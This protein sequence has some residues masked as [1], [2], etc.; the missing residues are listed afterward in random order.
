MGQRTWEHIKD[1]FNEVLEAGPDRREGILESEPGEVRRE[2]EAL[3]AAHERAKDAGDEDHP[4][5]EGPGSRIGRYKVLQEIGEGGFGVVYMAEQEEPVRRKVALKVIKLGMDTKQVIARFEAERQAL[6][7]LDHPNIAKVLDA[8][9]TETGRPYFVMELVKGIP[10]TEYCDKAS[11][12]TP[13]RLAL[14]TDV[15]R[16]I[17]HAHRKGIIHRD[18]KPSNVLVTLH[19]GKPVPKVI[20]FGIAKATDR[21]LTEKTLFTEFRQVVGTPDYMAPEQAELSSLDIDTRADVYSLGVLLYELLTGSKPFE[22]KT[23]LRQGW[24][25]ILRYIRE[26]DPPKPSTKLSTMGEEIGVVARNRRTPPKLL[27][28]LVRG[29]LDWIVLKALEKDRSRRY[30]SADAMAQDVQRFLDDQPVQATPPSTFYAIRKYVK[31]HK[32][33]VAAAAAVLL[34]LVVGLVLSSLGFLEASRQKGEAV[35]E[36]DAA[37]KAR[38]SEAEARRAADRAVEQA[39]LE[40]DEKEAARADLAEALVK[41]EG[42]RLLAQSQAVLPRDPA[43]A[44][45]LAIEGAERAPGFQANQALLAALEKAPLHE[46]TLDTDSVWRAAFGPRGERVATG[47]G[48]GTIRVFSADSG[49]EIRSFRLGDGPIA[50]LAWQ[51]GRDRIVA[52]G[53]DGEIGAWDPVGGRRLV[54]IRGDERKKRLQRGSSAWIND[55]AARVV[56]Y[57]IG[58][59]FQVFDLERGTL[60]RTLPAVEMHQ[61][62]VSP[63]G[64]WL[65]ARTERRSGPA[66]AYEVTVRSLETGEVR[67]AWPVENTNPDARFS[68][69][70][71]RVLLEAAEGVIHLLDVESGALLQEIRLEGHSTAAGRLNSGFSSDG[72]RVYVAAGPASG[73]WDAETGRRLLRIPESRGV[74]SA[75]MSPG[76]E[77]LLIIQRLEVATAKLYCVSSGVELWQMPIASM[78]THPL[79]SPDGGRILVTSHNGGA[80]I[81]DLTVD[82]MR[83]RGSGGTFFCPVGPDG[84]F[85]VNSVVTEVQPPRIWDLESRRPIRHLRGQTLYFGRQDNVWYAS[86]AVAA[87][88]D[89]RRIVTGSLFGRLALWDAARGT[90]IRRWKGH[91]EPVW[92]VA[93]SADGARI[94]SAGQD[95]TARIWDAATGRPLLTLGEVR[96]W[97]PEQGTRVIKVF[98]RWATFGPKGERILTRLADGDGVQVWDAVEGTLRFTCETLAGVPIGAQFTTDGKAIVVSTR[99]PVG[100]RTAVHDGRTGRRLHDLE[101]CSAVG[102]GNQLHTSPDGRHL[103]ACVAGEGVRIHEVASGELRRTLVYGRERLMCAWYSPDGRYIAAVSLSGRRLAVWEA[104]TGA[105]VLDLGHFNGWTS[106]VPFTLDSRKILVRRLGGVRLVPLDP[107]P[108]ARAAVPRRL[109]PQERERYGLPATTE[110]SAS[111]VTPVERPESPWAEEDRMVERLRRTLETVAAEDEVRDEME[112][113]LRV[114]SRALGLPDVALVSVLDH[115]GRRALNAGDPIRSEHL[116]RAARDHARSTL[117]PECPTTTEAQLYLARALHRSGRAGEAERILREVVEILRRRCDDPETDKYVLELGASVLAQGRAEDAEAILREA[118]R[119]LTARSES[120]AYTRMAQSLLGT[121]LAAQG[122]FEEAEELLLAGCELAGT[123]RAFGYIKRECLDR[124]VRFYEERGETEKAAAWRAKGAGAD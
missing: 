55:A 108:V 30:D 12:D 123:H 93:F 16:A 58:D 104:R 40:R 74:I 97:K 4:G 121:A 70:G 61:P 57:R 76:G 54:T 46:V 101:G 88:P 6:A 63:D 29:D 42:T 41:S 8:G 51:P 115:H 72:R 3:L 75:T 92:S 67:R 117:G 24:D 7:I 102:C 82:P 44:L 64:R 118:R 105:M 59:E 19:D 50:A 14:F 11:L 84:R 91:E 124:L 53:D 10:V 77:R 23:L 112:M 109:T 114:A 94:L 78:L 80:R 15:C 89:G 66:G 5:P 68:P 116:F 98:G 56:T 39:K 38:A 2:V 1:L 62:H 35:A 43:L 48:D 100:F 21:R 47:H 20:D 65:V 83:I 22:L 33:R 107:L 95:E 122:R 113:E 32:V 9:A 79:L 90:L 99:S 45:L 52:V 96:P 87:S 60:V 37:Q 73:V 31:R 86:T 27:G 111:P 106:P 69:D 28:R 25:E 71:R 85:W 36:R 26:V 103:L 110:A 18:L 119:Q 34:A 49:E 120:H 13:E 17:Q 81:W